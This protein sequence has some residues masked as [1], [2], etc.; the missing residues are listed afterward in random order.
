MTSEKSE[1]L[2][3]K[4][5]DG[6][7]EGG[8]TPWRQG[9]KA[10]FSSAEVLDHL[11]NPT[12]PAEPNGQRPPAPLG[13]RPY[14]TAAQADADYAA[15][16]QA[17]AE[18]DT[19]YTLRLAWDE[20]KAKVA[21]WDKANHTVYDLLVKYTA[22]TVLASIEKFEDE[23]LDAH[24]A[25]VHR[26]RDG[27]AAWE[28]I[29]DKYEPKG[30]LAV[31]NL[32]QKLQELRLAKGQ[33]PDKLFNAMNA[34]ARQLAAR[35]N[36]MPEPM[37]KTMAL[38]KLQ[39][40]GP[41]YDR[42][43]DTFLR[44]RDT[45]LR[46]LEESARDFYT[47]YKGTKSAEEGAAK[48]LAALRREVQKQKR[49]KSKDQCNK[50][51]RYGHHS[52][53]CPNS[54]AA[55]AAGGGGGR[56]R[57]GQRGGQGAGRGR[58]GRRGGRGGRR[59]GRGLL[60]VDRTPPDPGAIMED[61]EEY[62]EDGTAL[63]LRSM[64]AQPGTY[65]RS[66]DLALV[67]QN[68]EPARALMGQGGVPDP[69]TFVSDSGAEHHYMD[70]RNSHLVENLRPHPGG[71]VGAGDHHMKYTGR[72]DFYADVLTED[73]QLLSIK[74]D[75][76]LVD[77][78]GCNLWSNSRCDDQGGAVIYHNG[79]RIVIKGKTLPLTRQRGLYILK[80]RPARVNMGTSFF[81]FGFIYSSS[82]KMIN[83]P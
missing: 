34:T 12:R 56:G 82:S 7:Q 41:P 22:E 9:I 70:S 44:G 15:Q 40:Y 33:H 43:S 42:L 48:A 8:W 53:E 72:G 45:S 57:G 16:I 54:S 39:A 73:G 20:E 76:L 69:Y 80:L 31:L 64:P 1:R 66:V 35:G 51:F 38:A 6:R 17:R 77:K 11:S 67:I 52:Y 18:W 79:G 27:L 30:E 83:S 65:F 32:S 74:L 49:D 71:V 62:D 78:L 28:H 14:I 50:C 2:F 63:T 29:K 26:H 24:G 58:G 60:P 19:A 68:L 3:M 23:A 46:A 81:F 10:L 75:V 25:I 5:F 37:F 61:D 55:D 59:G 4:K 21:A 47:R 13:T 36:P